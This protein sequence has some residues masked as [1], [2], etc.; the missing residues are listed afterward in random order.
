VSGADREPG[1]TS[2]ARAVMPTG[3]PNLD[4][5]LGGG[6]RR[7]A[8][9]MVI[10]PPGAGKTIL[11]QQAAFAAARRGEPVLYL[12]GY[13][14]THEK[15]VAYTADLAFF[16][17]AMIPERIQFASLSDLLA[18]GPGATEEA[19][20]ASARGHR[21]RLVVLDGFGSMRRLLPDEAAA[22]AFVYS[23]GAKMAYLGATTL[24]VLEGNPEET[25][26]FGELTVSDAVLS[27]RRERLGTRH[28]RVLEV[29]KARGAAPLGGVHPFTI[30]DDGLHVHPRVESLPPEVDAPW[31]P[32]RASLG[33]PGVDAL[34]GGGPNVGTT[35]LA[36]GNLG[37]GKT[38]LGLHFLLAGARAGEPGLY[39]GFLETAAQLREQARVFGLDLAGSEASGLVRALVQA[40]YEVEPDRVVEELRADI[41]RRGVRRLV[42][43]SVNELQRSLVPAERQPEFFAALVAYLRARDVT[44]YMALDVPRLVGALELADSALGVL[45]ENVLVLRQTEYRGA[46]H[47]LLSILKMRFSGH[48]RA[49]HEFTITPGRGIE[50]VGPAPAGTG[51]LAGL[52]MPLDGGRPPP[53]RRR[54]RRPG[55]R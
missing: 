49:I 19:V 53:P 18:R 44:S 54:R 48:D 51:L 5:V 15:L 43:D 13:S 16:D 6:I 36:A 38:L 21:A 30:G 27:L 39:L 12:T 45:A 33:A 8:I 29:L 22:A 52:A 32:A 10:G 26:R 31:R 55:A 41:E 24:I 35:T 25:S 2:D 3:V 47:R 50:V 1:G 14:E 17:A 7:G 46:M 34:A 37:T 28:R 40:S 23:L 4:L 42:V 9:A 20:V 11:A